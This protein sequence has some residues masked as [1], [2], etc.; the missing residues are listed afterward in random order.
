MGS[1]RD[2]SGCSEEETYGLYTLHGTGTGT[3]TKNKRFLYYTMYC[4]PYTVTRIGNHCFLLCPSHSLSLSQ[5]RSRGVCM[6]HQVSKISKSGSECSQE[7]IQVG[8]ITSLQSGNDLNIKI[9]VNYSLRN[10]VLE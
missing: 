10:F 4:K 3:G 5:S 9:Q 7:V 6:S 8:M 2:G 1:R